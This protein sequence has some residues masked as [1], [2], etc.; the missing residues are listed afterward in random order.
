MIEI[1]ISHG[2]L[3]DKIT[4]LEIKQ[5]KIQDKAKLKEVSNELEI[6]NKVVETELSKSLDVLL[7]LKESLK[8][9][10]LKLWE[11]EDKLRI[12][13]KEK[14]FD[15]EF[16]ELARKVYY[17]NDE[18]FENKNKINLLFDSKLNEVKEYIEYK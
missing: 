9:T 18:R 11:V 15:E 7:D 5:F 17:L 13:E 1:K 10:N 2:E 3:I 16:I 6:L 4:I 14:I 12:K 8:E